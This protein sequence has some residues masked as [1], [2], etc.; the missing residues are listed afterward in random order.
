MDNDNEKEG[1]KMDLTYVS[2]WEILDMNIV[3]QPPLGKEIHL[4]CVNGQKVL[5][6]E[7]AKQL[8]LPGKRSQKIDDVE[9]IPSK[10]TTFN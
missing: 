1:E 4:T 7:I 9:K 6:A 3:K 10:V 8:S 2:N 5:G